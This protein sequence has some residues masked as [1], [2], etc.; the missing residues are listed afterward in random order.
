MAPITRRAIPVFSDDVMSSYFRGRVWDFVLSAVSHFCTASY[1]PLMLLESLLI[2]PSEKAIARDSYNT[3]LVA[4]V[5]YPVQADSHQQFASRTSELS[6]ITQIV[7]QEIFV[8]DINSSMH[9][10]SMCL[11]V[12][13]MSEFRPFTSE[14]K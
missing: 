1:D 12:E 7:Y 3:G 9:N 11:S 14:P 6:R 8:S 13:F 5:T 2:C 4:L 10:E